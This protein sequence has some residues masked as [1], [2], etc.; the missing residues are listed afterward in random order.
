MLLLEA[1]YRE[2]VRNPALPAHLR[3]AMKGVAVLVRKSGRDAIP[4]RAGT[5]SYWTLVALVPVLVLVALVLRGL[6]LEAWVSLSSFF[7]RA[8]PAILPSWGAVGL[9]EDLSAGSIGTVGLVVA[10]GASIRIFLAA[11]E[12][13]NRVWN[14]R[15]K[16]ALFTRLAL[17]YATITLAPVIVAVSASL[18]ARAEIATD[19]HGLHHLTPTLITAS[20]FVF[21]IRALPD[22]EVRW[23]P[24]LVG[25]LTSAA[26]FE[27]A[28]EGFAFY[29]TYFARSDATALIYGSLAF[30]PAFLLFVYV[31][32]TIVLLGVE[33][34]VVMQRWNELARAEERIIQGAERRAPDALFAVQCLLVVARRFSADLGGS[35]EPQVTAALG[36]DADHVHTAL[37]LLEEAGVLHET[38]DH[39]YAPAMKLERITVGDV[40]HRYRERSRPATNADAPGAEFVEHATESAAFSRTIA[41]LIAS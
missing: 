4:V 38:H 8:L 18:T 12:A 2:Q 15:V 25:G 32:W 5:L 36:S 40:V 26:L 14:A 34:S 31:M 9:P 6:G 19:T 20:G 13:Y 16:K 27:A 11:E 10:F 17:Y 24:A 28:K 39:A 37:E 33:V 1:L 35:T 23:R 22:T 7:G 29:I 3:A 41:E 30:V 21:A